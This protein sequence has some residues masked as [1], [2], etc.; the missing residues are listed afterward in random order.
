MATGVDTTYAGSDGH[1][2]CREDL[3]DAYV[4]DAG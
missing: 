4:R 1:F 2:L 3:A